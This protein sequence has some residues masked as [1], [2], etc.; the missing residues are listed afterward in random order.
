LLKD[1]GNISNKMATES[2]TTQLKF[3]AN[4]DAPLVYVPSKGGGD[5][6]DHVGNYVM[7][8]VT[9][10]DARTL[11]E[12]SLDVEGFQLVTHTTAVQDFYDDRQVGATYHDEVKRLLTAVTGA[13][14]VE[15]FDDTRRTSSLDV[16]K[17]RRIRE[18]ADL[19]HNDYTAKSGVK[20][21]Y[22]LFPDEAD[23]LARRRFAII[24]VWRSISGPVLNHPLVMCD[25][26]SVGADEL[27]SVERRA[28]DRI[29]ELQVATYS[30][31]QRWYYYPHMQ[32]DEA[33]V[34]K[35]FDSAVDGTTRFTIHSSFDDP[36][37]P[38]DAP[39]RESIETRCMVFY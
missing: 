35:T 30:E 5:V 15:I 4:R 2:I 25:A 20:R 36:S 34:F 27:V 37:A 17:M 1:F 6:T 32:F 10:N 14:R 7:R 18:P 22:D 8:S 38:A 24:N 28:E 19:V 23:E 12:P 26:T 13:S 3:L 31:T 21:L 39:P 9:V 33:L 16:Q 11:A 29:G